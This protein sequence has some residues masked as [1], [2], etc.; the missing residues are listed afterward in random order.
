MNKSTLARSLF[1]LSVFACIQ[2][3]A[4]AFSQPAT[5]SGYETI[6]P[7]RFITDRKITVSNPKDIAAKLFI[8][9]RESE[10][11]KSDG[12]L[13]EYPTRETAVIVHTVVGLADDSVAGMRHRIEL[14]LRQNKWEIV[15]IGRQ[16]KCQPNRGHQNWASG[17]CK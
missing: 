10:G 16:S 11:R 13:V 1:F 14:R 9:D 5:R 15:W 8:L 12:I 2:I 4:A 3:P 6:N 17:R 7:K